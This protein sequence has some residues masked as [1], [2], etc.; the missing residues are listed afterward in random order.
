[1]SCYST[2]LFVMCLLALVVGVVAVLC[3][4]SITDSAD[5]AVQF[6]KASMV[7]SLFMLL[8]ILILYTI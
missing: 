6:Y 7:V 3:V 4:A 1:M 5:V 8:N 2:T